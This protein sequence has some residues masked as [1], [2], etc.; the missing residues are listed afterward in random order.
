MNRRGFCIFIDTVCEGAIP[1][2]KGT[3]ADDGVKAPEGIYLFRS[4]QEA[5]YEIAD[6]MITRL[7][8]FLVGERDFEDAIHL[9]EYVVEVDV[10]PDGRIVDAEGRTVFMPMP[11]TAVDE[12]DGVVFRQ[13][14]VGLAGE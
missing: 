11:E 12:D 7:Q 2:V 6:A 14:E 3:S 13:D 4:E 1:L 5:Q 10:L 9:E 8:E